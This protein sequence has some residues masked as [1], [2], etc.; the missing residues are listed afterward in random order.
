MQIHNV[1]AFT[2]EKKKFKCFP[3]RLKMT[4]YPNFTVIVEHSA[5]DCLPLRWQDESRAP[6]PC[7]I[8]P[9]SS[10]LPHQTPAILIHPYS[11]MVPDLDKSGF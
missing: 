3:A 9:W 4:L 1:A 10:V 8:I 5:L 11:S 2:Q 7:R 6:Y